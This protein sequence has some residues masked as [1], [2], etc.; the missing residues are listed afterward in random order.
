MVFQ[1]A[2]HGHCILFALFRPAIDRVLA[3]VSTFQSGEDDCVPTEKPLKSSENVEVE[4]VSF[5]GE[6]PEV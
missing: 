5:G 1:I 2:I 3:V 4:L 6:H